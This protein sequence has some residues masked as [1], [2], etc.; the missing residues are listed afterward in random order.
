MAMNMDQMQIMMAKMH[1]QNVMYDTQLAQHFQEISNVF[2]NMMDLSGVLGIKKRVINICRTVIKRRK[3]KPKFGRCDNLVCCIAMTAQMA[4]QYR[5]NISQGVFVYSVEG[6]S[7]ADKAGLKMGDVITKV[8][9][10]DIATSEDLVAAKK[11]Y[12]AGDT[13]TFTI[14]RDGKTQTVKVTCI[15][16]TV[17]R[18]WFTT[19]WRLRPRSSTSRRTRRRMRS[20]ASVS[21]KILISN[22]SRRTGF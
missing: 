2:S 13:S 22:I 10:T 19:D 18:Y 1:Q 4:E 15:G 17:V 5:Y 11:S 7:A 6:G 12:S 14:Y 9:D 20:S 16:F 21:T 8:D 3:Q